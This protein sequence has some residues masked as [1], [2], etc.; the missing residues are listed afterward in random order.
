MSD[1]VNSEIQTPSRFTL[2]RVSVVI[3]M[4]NAEK[5]VGECLESILNQTFQNFEVVIVD[6]CSTDSSCAI[7]ESYAEKFGGRLKLAHL[8]KNSGGCALPRNKGLKLS[9]GEYIFIMD[10]DDLLKPIALEEMYVLAKK[11]DADVVYFE[12]LYVADFVTKKFQLVTYQKGGNADKPTLE[13]EDLAQRV[14]GILDGKYWVTTWCK[15][16]RRD[17][18]MEHEIFFPN[19]SIGDDDI[20]T[21]GLIFYA[22]K[23][24][25]VPDGV[26]F[27][28]TNEESVLRKRKTP[29]QRIIF[30]TNPILLALKTLDNFMGNLEFFQKNLRCRYAVLEKFITSKILDPHINK[31]HLPPFEIYETIK[32]E[33]GAKFG[34]HDVLVCALC[35]YAMNLQKNCYESVQNFNQF[36]KQAQQRIT[37][38]EAELAKRN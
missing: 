36:A 31:W 26:Y 25:R 38:L 28:R 16:V 9:R 3:P 5:F 33:F 30:W 13:T 21:Y 8:E 10:A 12:M 27:Y 35:T 32:K 20:W 6:D 4:F 37:Q 22:K 14:Q 11:F 15:L 24:L 17:L 2:P 34:E 1:F 19:I 23:I 7:V 18:M 29:E